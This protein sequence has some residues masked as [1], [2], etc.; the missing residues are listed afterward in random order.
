MGELKK[1]S[2]G[3]TRLSRF[4]Y[5]LWV[6]I[7]GISAPILIIAGTFDGAPLRYLPALAL[8]V[9]LSTAA[10]LIPALTLF[11]AEQVRSKTRARSRKSWGITLFLCLLTGPLGLHR[12][13]TGHYWSV[14]FYPFTA[15]GLLL[16]WITDLLTILS[17]NFTDSSGKPIRRKSAASPGT[18]SAPK[19]NPQPKPNPGPRT[20][21]PTAE[22]TDTTI[23]GKQE[24]RE[25][26]PKQEPVSQTPAHGQTPPPPETVSSSNP[27]AVPKRTPPTQ[28]PDDPFSSVQ[29]AQ[30]NRYANKVVAHARNVPLNKPDASYT[31]MSYDQRCWYFYWRTEVRNGRYPDTDLPYILLHIS[32]L[33]WGVGWDHPAIGRD[34]LMT[35]WRRYRST[36]PKLDR[37]MCDWMFDFSRTYQLPYEVPVESPVQLPSQTAQRNLLI[38]THRSDK[39]LKLSWDLIKLLSDYQMEQS[40][41]YQAE[42]GKIIQ[43]AVPRVIALADAALLKKGGKG[44]LAVYGPSRTTSQKYQ[45]FAGSRCPDADR[46]VSVSVPPYCTRSKLREFIT[47]LVKHTENV[48]RSIYSHRGR[49]RGITLEPETADLIETFLRKEYSPVTTSEEKDTPSVSLDFDSI[50][51]L[52]RQSDAVRNALEVQES[53]SDGDMSQLEEVKAMFACLSSYARALLDQLYRNHWEMD[54]SAGSQSAF[55]E[56]NQLSQRYLARQLLVMEEKRIILEEDFRDEMTEI[57][58]ALPIPGDPAELIPDSPEED[59]FSTSL[60]S[61]AMKS[62]L[63]SLLPSHIK[64]VYLIASSDNP[65]QQLEDLANEN[66]TMPEMMLDEIND[67]ALQFLDDV[68]IDT[69]QDYPQICEQYAAELKQALK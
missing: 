56:I 45:T 64:A 34:L 49:L 32:E 28:Q 31:D 6:W 10:L 19:G 52:R 3:G 46:T 37:L 66:M 63:E 67:M 15:G 11:R 13:Y 9:Y 39:P 4:L 30:M 69:F 68:L 65:T 18:K 25:P 50:D 12:L 41:F 26:I 55:T 16:S 62:L 43:E 8:A 61:E 42:Y 48:L 38:D 54:M 57:Y 5:K 17:G 33:L 58:S 53:D 47:G 40:S 35:L 20:Q 24:A 22:F 23:P 21:P 51:F 36:Y 29:Q 14:I 59:C 60:L 44:I 2:A 7:L 1:L 27:G